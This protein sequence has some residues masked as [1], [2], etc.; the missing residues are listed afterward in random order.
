MR[1]LLFVVLV[2]AFSALV[3]GSASAAQPV[4]THSTLDVG[5]L[6][7]TD[8]CSASI[9]LSGHLV[10]SET[11]YF[12]ANGSPTRVY[13]HAV[14][15]DTFTGPAHSLVSE[16]Y[17]YGTFFSLD[18]D[19]NIVSGQVAGVIVRIPLPDGSLFLSAGRVILHP[20]EP[21]FIFTPDLG[22]SAN[23]SAFCGALGA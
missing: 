21:V 11:D 23:L 10:L 17:Q 5:P 13:I 12:D 19:G 8:V 3:P 9:T 2:A 16:P 15:T 6:A 7:I 1:K 18:A 4:I 22:R 14:E 20:N